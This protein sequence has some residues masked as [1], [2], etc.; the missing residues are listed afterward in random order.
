MQTQDVRVAEWLLASGGPIIRYRV[1]TELLADRGNMDRAQL[2]RDLLACP[3]VKRWLTNLGQAG[4]DVLPWERGR[5]G[6][7]ALAGA[8]GSTARRSPADG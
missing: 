2:G 1:A 6:A 8:V 7:S 5:V 4:Q 3:E